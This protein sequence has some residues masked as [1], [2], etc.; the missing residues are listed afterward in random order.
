[1]CAL[2]AASCG[3]TGG[4]VLEQNFTSDRATLLVMEWDGELSSSQGTNPA[5]QI[6]GQLLFTVGQ[7]NAEF[8]VARLDKLALTRV[9][10]TAAGGGLYRI[11]YHARLPVAWGSQTDLPSTFALAL[12]RRMD[13]HGQAAFLLAY[14]ATC[15]D[16]TGEQVTAANF[17]FHYRPNQ[18][19]CALADGDVVR[20]TAS[21][22]VS[23]LNTQNRAPEY[24][25]VWEDGRLDVVA[26]FGKFAEGATDDNDAGISAFNAFVAA[27]RAQLGP[28][29]TVTPAGLPGSPGAAHPDVTLQLALDGGRQVS[30][31]ALLVTRWRPPVRPSSSATPKRRPGRI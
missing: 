6:R 9:A 16:Q 7:L 18:S 5:G 24:H 19:G 17:W 10:V 3:G 11:G 15:N 12:P 2:A 29:A 26:V 14:A 13:A 8:S 21:A 27:A 23:S 20:A 4:Q 1:M 28:S 25:K 22:T 30:I 31:V